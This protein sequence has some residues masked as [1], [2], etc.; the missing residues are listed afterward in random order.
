L[1]K[2]NFATAFG[3]SVGKRPERAGFGEAFSAEKKDARLIFT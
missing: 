1:G 2:I 3:I